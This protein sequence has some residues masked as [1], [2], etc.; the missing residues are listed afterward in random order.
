MKR[1]LII[2]GII[3]VILL[4]AFF[5]LRSLTKSNSPEAVAQYNQDGLSVTVNYCQPYK[6]GRKIF[7]GLVPYGEVWRTGANEATLINFDQGVTVAGKPLSAG[8]YSF[9]T[10][11]SQQGW[12]AIF[13]DETGQWGTNY[14]PK[15]DVMRVP[16]VARP[17]SPAA[18][19]FTI[20]FVPQPNGTDMM[21]VWDDTEAVVPIQKQ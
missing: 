16:I 6:K 5:T 3:A 4:A 10:I 12:I 8:E 15:R 19:Q 2:L 7:G 1:I 11:P 13:N 14:D 9:W 21:L 17:H 18:E 20:N